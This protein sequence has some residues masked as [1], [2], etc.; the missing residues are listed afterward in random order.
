[1]KIRLGICCFAL[2]LFLSPASAKVRFR[3][4]DLS[5]DNRLLFLADSVSDGAR[6]QNSLFISRLTDLALQQITA[7]PEKIELVEGGR[8]LQV[9][10]AF[11]ALRIPAAGGLPRNIPGFPS[12][13]AGAPVMGGRVEEMAASQDGRWVLYVDP[14]SAAYGNLVLIDVSTGAR[15]IAARNVERPDRFFPACWS[16]DSR[17]FVYSRGGRLYYYP[18]HSAPTAPA[19]ERYRLIGEGAINAVSWSRM[20]DFYY[21]KGSTVYR[22]RGSELFARAL[23]ADFLEIGAV[24]GKIPFEF[25]DNFDAFWIAPDSRSLLLSKGGRNIF[26]YPLDGSDLESVLPYV[27]I[28]RSAYKLNVLWSPAGVITVIASVIKDEGSQVMAWRLETGTEKMSFSPLATPVGS[29][30]ALSPDGSRALFWG[31]GGIV[32]YDYINWKVLLSLGTRPAYSC[33]WIN[34]EELITG[35][36]VRIDRIKLSGPS[37]GGIQRTMICLSG[38]TEYGFE[39][40]GSRILAKNGGA[41]FVSDGKSPWEETANPAVRKASLVSGRY[42]VYLER[43]SSGPYENLPMIRNTASVGTAPLLTRLQYSRETSL[44]G[45]LAKN[46]PPGIFSHGLREGLRETALC[47][48]LYD[49][50]AGLPQVLD[51]LNR[52]GIRATFFMNGEFIRRYPQAARDIAN[53]GHEA[54]SMFFVPINLSDARYRVGADFIVRGLAR[55]EDEYF[56]ATGSELS[57]LWH[58]PY[59]NA[60]AEIA[61][62]ALRAGYLTVDRD[63]DPLDWVSRDDAKTLGITQYSASAMID[64][65]MSLKRPGSIVP[66]RLGLLPGGRRDYLYLRLEVLLDALVQAGYAVVPV[67]TIIEHAR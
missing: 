38:A 30:G 52:F 14:V 53:A 41:W 1:M 3:G 10:N 18:I 20:G 46:S 34:N 67:S 8:F 26:Y 32:L 16:P 65:I 64:R 54:A 44:A 7:F 55:N 22:V 57:L 24:A 60:S 31:E 21:L 59:F 6:S 17:V 2:I 19:D 33:L 58:A 61:A 49:D 50:A 28:P 42:R 63:V 62:A 25:D 51:I 66:I 47:F 23:Y 35:D 43:Q 29:Q 15:R 36:K 9:R 37:G 5:D 12:F 45:G 56:Q 11:G 48:D 13:A 39:E 40:K 27:I 4:L